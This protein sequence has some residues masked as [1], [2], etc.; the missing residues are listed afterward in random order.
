VV[1]FS[2]LK[3]FASDFIFIRSKDGKRRGIE[4]RKKGRKKEGRKEINE[5]N[6]I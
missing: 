2:D 4:E 1:E 5:G 3:N 6:K